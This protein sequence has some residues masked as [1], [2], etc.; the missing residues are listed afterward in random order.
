LEEEIKATLIKLIQMMKKSTIKAA[1]KKKELN[2]DVD[3]NNGRS[4]WG[5]LLTTH[6]G[7]TV[8][9][10]ICARTLIMRAAQQ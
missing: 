5:T 7:A 6:Y 4:L 8:G 2:R 3:K 9:V 1:M 10:V